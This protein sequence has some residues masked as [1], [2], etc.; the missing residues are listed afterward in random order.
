MR[1]E[2]IHR[3]LP[4]IILSVL[5]TIS[6][7]II[8]SYVV[9]IISAFIIT[10]LIYPIHKK[11]EKKMPSNVA[12]GITLASIVIII[13]LPLT[14]VIKEI[15]SQ[16][17]GAIQ[18]GKVLWVIE[19]IESFGPIASYNLN[20]SDL[21]NNFLSI[22][23]KTLSGITLSVT[24]SLVSFFVMIFVS[25]Y[26]ILN[27][28]TLK[29]KVKNYIPFNNKEKIIRD[30]ADITKKIVRGTLLL[31]L[32]ESLVA[33]IGFRLA[34]IDSYLILAVLIG[35]FAFI[36]GGPAIVW[37]PTLIIKMIQ[38]DYLSSIIILIFGLFISVYLD[39]ILRTKIAGKESRIHP[40]IMLLGVMGGTP[41]LGLAGIIVGP[42]LLSYT[43]EILEEILKEH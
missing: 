3:Y 34:G 22:G 41:L 27:W 42:L 28:P 32:I 43:L 25:Y 39:T 26:L 35:L 18:S 4:I 11:L 2:G 38:G 5:V 8:K 30:I 37:V 33:G 29:I 1:K 24:A 23:V 17:Y 9:A 16:I 12:A 40:A 14:L 6:L 31:A 13:L 7:L 19:K 20:L 10:Y 21:T 36:P 15:V